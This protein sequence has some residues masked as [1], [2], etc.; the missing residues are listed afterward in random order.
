MKPLFLTILLFFAY[1]LDAQSA[2]KGRVIDAKTKEPL[3][4]V[5][6][7]INDNPH[8]GVVTD[9]DGNFNYKSNINIQTL[10]FSY[11]GYEKKIISLDTEKNLERL[12][13]GLSSVNLNLQE[14][15]IKAGENPAHRIIRKVIANRKINNPENVT[16]F[17]YTSYNKIMAD[18]KYDQD[19][20]YSTGSGPKIT[21]DSMQHRM[22]AYLK[23]GHLMMMESTTERK[24]LYPKRNQE[25]ILGTKTSGFKNL[26]IPFS[27]TDFQ[28]VSFYEDHFQLMETKYLSPIAQG[29][30]NHYFFNI[31][32][33]IF[34]NQDTVF[35]ISFKP[36]LGKN[37]NGMKGVLQINT[38]RYAIQNVIAE[39]AEQGL[40]DM[41]IQQKYQFVD[42]KQWFPEQLNFEIWVRDVGMLGVEF[43]LVYSGKCYIDNVELFAD[44]RSKDF[45]VDDVIVDEK[46]NQHDSSFWNEKRTV[47]LEQKE[48]ATY[49]HWDTLREEFAEKGINLDNIV[50]FLEKIVDG[51]IAIRWFDL[52]LSKMFVTNEFEGFRLGLGV[53]T[54]EKLSKHFTVGG[55]FGYGTNDYLW[56]YGGECALNFSKEHE[57]DLRIGYQNTLSETGAPTLLYN[58]LAGQNLLDLRKRLASQMDQI[59]K[60]TV[61]FGFRAFRYAKF[62]IVLDQVRVNPLYT[63][64]YQPDAQSGLTKYTYTGLNVGMRYA[65]KERFVRTAFQRLSMGTKYPII[66]L[67]YTRGISGFLDGEFDFN[68]INFRLDKTFTW[69]VLGESKV[70]ID[71]GFVDRP[72]PYG[73]LYT[74]EGDLDNWSVFVPDYFQTMGKYE[75]LSDQYTNVFLSHN[76]GSL[77]FR[78]KKFQPHFIVHHNMGWGRLSHPEYQQNIE[79]KTKEKGFIE[80]GLQIDQILRLNCFNFFYFYFGAGAYYRYGAY[81][82]DVANENLTFKLSLT[83]STR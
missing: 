71:A 59:E 18:Y 3:A 49:Q 51:K 22:D 70:R 29:S 41:K 16:S 33:T 17:K 77:F 1:M 30:L 8:L 44:L 55:F 20:Y 74:G 43:G 72:L 60:K 7:K 4:F 69:K 31:E 57:I 26:S 35:V 62:N 63:Y 79:F 53:S 68:K 76:F 73:L 19:K 61:D 67:N 25:T 39:P 12:V 24:Y 34:Q 37:I 32:D 38:N 82:S 80:S 81:A 75:F 5:N 65:F 52:D 21:G 45:S 2:V 10:T 58:P 27:A 15:T 13:I 11:V 46:V 40:W 36:K 42:N 23:G 48:T 47:A 9:I 28:P 54:N 78:I 56:K 50:T 83:V 64:K 14:V 6:I 66:Y